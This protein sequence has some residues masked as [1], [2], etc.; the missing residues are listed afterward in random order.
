MKLRV[1]HW[2]TPTESVL[3]KLQSSHNY[4]L[5]EACPPE[6]PAL[7]LEGNETVSAPHTPVT[8][9]RSLPVEDANPVTRQVQPVRLTSNRITRQAQHSLVAV[10]WNTHQFTF[11][12]D[13]SKHPL[14]AKLAQMMIMEWKMDVLLL[15]EIPKEKGLPRVHKFCDFLNDNV[16]DIE[17]AFHVYSSELSG[18]H[19]YNGTEHRPEYHV[20]LVRGPIEVETVHTHHRYLDS[21]GNGYKLDHAPFTLFLKDTRFR[22]QACQRVALTSVHLPPSSRRVSR[23]R[24]GIGFL[25][26][27]KHQWGWPDELKSHRPSS[28][29]SMDKPFCTHIIGGDFNCSAADNLASTSDW[30]VAFDDSVGTSY[31]SQAYDNWLLNRSAVDKVWLDVTKNV[32]A[33]PLAQHTRDGLSDHDAIILT[34]VEKVPCR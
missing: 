12:D 32:G 30:W 27:Y 29:A 18:V 22:Q 9:P 20:A 16:A 26:S 5:V 2:K 31:G 10:S 3:W 8:S 23:D 15:S 4:E 25:E 19:S 6:M 1:R 28:F 34:L 17:T 13:E 21:S 14:L 7:E 24:Q 11:M 33:L